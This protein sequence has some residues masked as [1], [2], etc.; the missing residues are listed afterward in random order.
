MID[1]GKLHIPPDFSHL[2]AS[3]PPHQISL[4]ALARYSGPVVA[5]LA[6]KQ[7]PD[8]APKWR[9]LAVRVVEAIQ[10]HLPP[11]AGA[12]VE[13]LGRNETASV[14]ETIHRV[15]TE[16][17]RAP[18]TIGSP[19]FDW[20]V[21]IQALHSATLSIQSWDADS[22]T[23]AAR[24]LADAIDAALALEPDK[25]NAVALQVFNEVNS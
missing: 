18:P 8:L 11:V 3:I 24:W 15:R 22:P 19:Q 20:P 13:R 12:A 21:A 16:M 6:V 4:A 1:L 9:L 10:R 5:A 14:V 2:K 17:R 7:E 25:V 23:L